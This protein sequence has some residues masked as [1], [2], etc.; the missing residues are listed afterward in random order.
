MNKHLSA[1][2]IESDP[3]LRALLTALLG[4]SGYTVHT[5]QTAREGV[6]LTQKHHP[7]LVT[8]ELCLS[9]MDGLAATQAIRAFSDAYILI[10]SASQD[11]LDVCVVLEAGADDYINKP[12]S[13]RILQAKVEALKRRPRNKG[14][15]VPAVEEFPRGLGLN[16]TASP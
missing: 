5:A 3:D 6:Q 13:P 8:T 11:P 15:V 7:D 9:G 10:I 12:V 14:P 16:P 1:I 2:V 4:E